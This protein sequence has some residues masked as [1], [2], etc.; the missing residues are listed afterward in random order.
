MKL[1]LKVVLA[2]TIVGAFSCRKDVTI[3]K[4]VPHWEYENPDWKN[5]GYSDCGGNSQ[6]PINVMTSGTIPSAS[7]SGITFNYTPFPLKIV[8]NGHTIQVNAANPE[9]SITYGGKPYRF[10][11]LHLHHKSE[12]KI[13]N[14]Q[15]ALELHL[16][17]QDA[18]G[19]LLVLAYM[20]VQGAENPLISQMLANV[21]T[22]QKTEATLSNVLVNLLNIQPTNLSYYTYFGSLTTPP[23]STSV[24]FVIFKEKMQAS[25]KQIT[26]FAGHYHDN[27]RPIQPLNNRLILEKL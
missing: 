12:H 17:H 13:N 26:D 2:I 22:K 23:C 27:A 7:L 24:Q 20:V 4:E 16:V 15:T 25:A 21:P 5:I 18:T 6:S 1:S 19:N 14:E 3:I 8:D 9:N 10:L 11:Q